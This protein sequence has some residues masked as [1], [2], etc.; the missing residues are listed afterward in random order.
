MADLENMYAVGRI[1]GCLDVAHAQVCFGERLEVGRHVHR[2]LVSAVHPAHPAG[3]H[4]RQAR[5]RENLS[6]DA[7]GILHEPKGVVPLPRVNDIKQV[8]RDRLLLF[9]AH[10][11]EIARE[12][13]E[14]VAAIREVLELVA[15]DAGAEVDPEALDVTMM[16]PYP[17]SF[18]CRN[19]GRVT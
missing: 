12:E 17:C 4:Q 6:G 13:A 9:N 14:A 8:R 5:A 10:G 18:M 2:R 7:V 3:H 16:R 1:T 11:L 19:A 15:V